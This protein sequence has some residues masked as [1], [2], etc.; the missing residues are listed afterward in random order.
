MA[1]DPTPRVRIY[2][3][4]APKEKPPRAM[5]YVAAVE[6]EE[7]VR[8]MLSPRA[9]RFTATGARRHSRRIRLAR[10]LLALA[11]LTIASVVGAY[12]IRNGLAPRAGE[13]AALTGDD[14]RMVNPR[15]TGRDSAGSP[16]VVTADAAVRGSEGPRLTDLESPRLE[17][18]GGEHTSSIVIAERGVYNRDEN[19][20]ELFGDVRYE[21]D[22][23]Y[24]FKTSHARIYP[25][26]GRIVGER[27]IEGGGPMGMLRADGFEILDSGDRIVFEGG[28]LARMEQPA[29]K[30]DIDETVAEGEET[31]A[32][33]TDSDETADA[34]A[35]GDDARSDEAAGDREDEPT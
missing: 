26:E 11:I 32:A 18:H 25:S 15:F 17:F 6:L 4:F 21:S 29:P 19:W 35:A 33:A 24:V 20:L 28:V 34:A 2:C 16:F 27:V 7:D 10:V 12:A 8:G 23:G 3:A 14:V 1:F 9:R 13:L 5:A 30:A 31:E 22:N